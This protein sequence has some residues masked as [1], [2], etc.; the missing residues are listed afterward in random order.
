MW[1]V[2]SYCVVVR[3]SASHCLTPSPL[4]QDKARAAVY[5]RDDAVMRL[6]REVALQRARAGGSAALQPR[7][8]AELLGERKVSARAGLCM[9]VF[10]VVG[11]G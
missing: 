8:V 6:K 11:V 4:R 7:E 10:V 3:H 2:S 9:C 1:C 5:E